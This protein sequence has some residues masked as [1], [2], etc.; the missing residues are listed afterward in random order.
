MKKDI[1]LKKHE[2]F[3]TFWFYKSHLRASSGFN[4]NPEAVYSVFK[5]ISGF[6]FG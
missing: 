6:E 1:W 4:T 3:W 5:A 2:K